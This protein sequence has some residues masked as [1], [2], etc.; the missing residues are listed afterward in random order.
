MVTPVD[1]EPE[2]SP[3][4]ADKPHC[5]CCN[6]N[7]IFDVYGTIDEL[8]MF[9][10]AVSRWDINALEELPLYMRSSFKAVYDI[11]NEIADKIYVQHGFNPKTFL[12]KSAN[13][14][15]KIGIVSSGVHVVLVHIFFM[16]GNATNEEQACLV[17]DKH[18]IISSVAK[19]LRLWDDFGSAEDENQDGHDGSYI[20][21]FL[22]EHEGCSV[23]VAHEHAENLISDTWKCLN[24]ECLSPNPGSTTFIMAAYNLAR[25]VPLMYSYGEDGSLPLIDNKVKSILNNTKIN[26]ITSLDLDL[27]QEPKQI[28]TVNQADGGG[29]SS[30]NGGAL[31][32]GDATN[33]QLDVNVSGPTNDDGDGG[34]RC[35]GNGGTLISSDE[36]TLHDEN[37][38]LTPSKSVANPN[39][40]T[41]YANLFT[42]GPSRKAMNFHTLF[43]PAG[44]RVDVGVTVESIKAISEQFANTEY[45]YSPSSLPLR[46]GR[47]SYAK[48]LIEV[49]ADVGLKDN[50]V[51]AM[52]KLVGKGFY[53]CNDD[54]PKNIH[55]NVVNNMKKPSY[56]PRG[57]P[58]SYVNGDYD[59]D[60]YD[61]DMYEGQDIPDKIQDICNNLDI[62]VQGRKKK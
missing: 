7:G 43:T 53:T 38:G 39:K 47:S 36:D 5:G 24:K 60:P 49:W 58:D 4:R 8:T 3:P 59:F 44:N 1:H 21:Y 37:D 29:Y 17:K 33:T 19:I 12:W 51:V 22:N 25:L 50:I 40:G 61:D 42:G 23:M 62:K 32:F 45:G 56:T 55:S 18:A 9:T 28:T 31:S 11:T 15:L 27:D 30:G 34:A 6:C 41:S 54:C 57:V 26:Q 20:Q 14:Y 10:K 13:E 16:L 46:M 52:P 48:A 2:S 35:S